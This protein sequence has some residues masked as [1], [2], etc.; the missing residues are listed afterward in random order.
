MGLQVAKA[1][2]QQAPQYKRYCSLACAEADSHAALTAPVHGRLD[3]AAARVKVL[4]LPPPRRSFRPQKK[5]P[6]RAMSRCP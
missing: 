4:P 1:L 6:E 2:L 3:G 5:Y